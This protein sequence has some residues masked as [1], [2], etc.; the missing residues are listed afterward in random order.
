MSSSGA[1]IEYV[2]S[3]WQQQSQNLKGDGYRG[4]SSLNILKRF[5]LGRNYE[6]QACRYLQQQGLT[7]IARN[8]RSKLGEIDII[9]QDT[10]HLIFVEVRYRKNEKYGSSLES[11]NMIKQKKIM[12]TAIIFLKKNAW[13]K[14]L[15]YRF[16]VVSYT[17]DKTVKWI[18]NA[19]NFESS[20][21]YFL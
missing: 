13:T 2:S 8:F 9:M 10:S 21:R 19:F 15:N 1:Y 16:D 6:N 5:T 14:D 18:K 20:Y 17:G 3:E 4:L 7:L 11:V 12:L